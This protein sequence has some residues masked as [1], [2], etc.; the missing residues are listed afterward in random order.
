MVDAQ[1]IGHLCSLSKLSLTE[2]ELQGFTSDMETI[3]GIMDSINEVEVTGAIDRDPGVL[4]RDLRED[5]A[6]ESYDT[7]AM[8]ENARERQNGTFSVPKLF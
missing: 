1:L 8:L 7:E 4:F 6:K 5:V 3:M 2:E